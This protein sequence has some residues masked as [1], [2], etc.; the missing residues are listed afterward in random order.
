MARVATPCADACPPA[1]VALGCVAA[2]A[3]AVTG[4][5]SPMP[6]LRFLAPGHWVY[7]TVLQAAIHVDGSTG[8]VDAGAGV[9]GD[10]GSQ[11]VQGDTSGYVVGRSKITVFGTSDLGVQGTLAPPADEVPL[12]LEGTG[13]PYLVYQQAGKVAR[14]G[15][16]PVTITVGGPVA[17]PVLTA[18]GTMWLLRKGNGLL[19]ELLPGAAQ[20]GSCPAATPGGHGGSLSLL[21]GRPSYVDATA[22]ELYPV[23]EDGLGPATHLGVAGPDMVPSATDVAGRLALLDPKTHTLRLVDPKAP[24]TAPVTVTLPDGDYDGPAAGGSAVTVVDRRTH[25][26]LTY[27]DHGRQ[28]DRKTL[29]A[30][31]GEPRLTRGED[32]RVY[33]EGTQGTEV[34]VV[35]HDGAVADVPTNLPPGKP[36]AGKPQ[37]GKPDPAGQDENAGHGADSTLPPGHD[38]NTRSEEQQHQ[39]QEPQQPSNHKSLN[40]RSSPSNPNSPSS[41]NRPSGPRRRPWSRPVR[42]VL[43]AGSRPRRARRPRPSAGRRPRPTAHR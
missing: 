33:V 42:P 37:N 1:L 12:A 28:R 2:V 31:A 16:R 3:V 18:D 17:D 23:G 30:S 21:S 13:G 6:A 24:D 43:L 11:I 34:M 4:A 41:R 35:D 27:D 22:G 10:P 5:A 25:T 15:E 20:V 32:N 9:P 36:D 19:C 26:V 40:T 39:T 14:L 38:Q 29:P 7:N 8:T